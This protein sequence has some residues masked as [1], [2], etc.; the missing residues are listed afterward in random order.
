MNDKYQ[1]KYRISSVR[2]QNWNYGAIGAY[3]ITICT[4]DRENYFGEIV[5]G[6]MQL[7]EIGQIVEN[8]WLK[9]PEIRA[10]MNLQSGVFI[11]MPNHF[12]PQSKNLASIMRGFKSV[13]TMQA[14]TIRVDFAWQ[15]RYYDHIIRNSE[16]FE[17]IQ[18]YIID[19]PLDWINDQFYK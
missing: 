19:N 13:I 6:I 14:K 8:E 7:N 17:T 12:G 2:L 3:Y 10:D 4:N 18:N 16:S 15:P 5:N 11:V 9:T 1:N